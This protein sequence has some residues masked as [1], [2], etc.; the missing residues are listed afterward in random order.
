MS[1]TTLIEQYGTALKNLLEKG[2]NT[3]K[4]TKR[5]QGKTESQLLSEITTEE[6]D[7]DNVP[8]YP[9]A[10]L[11]EAQEGIREDRL[12][13]ANTVGQFVDG[14][15]TVNENAIYF[16]TESNTPMAISAKPLASPVGLIET[17][18]EQNYILN[19]N[20]NDYDLEW[21]Y[22]FNEDVL[23]IYNGSDWIEN[24]DADIS[25][26]EIIEVGRFYFNPYTNR[27]FFYDLEE[28]IVRF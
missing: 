21:L 18:E 20:S 6:L 13:T 24:N 15:F 9:P 2:T 3:A 5:L 12:S 14:V 16:F 25:L 7:L 11:Q 19:L 10:T 1:L 26:N 28:N 22:N 23:F 17:L 4:N 8:N 27:L